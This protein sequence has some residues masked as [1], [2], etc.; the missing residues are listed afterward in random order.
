MPA[1]PLP[2]YY[3]ILGVEPAAPSDTIKRA[4]RRQSAVSHPDKGGSVGTFRL[5]QIAYETLADPDRRTIYDRARTAATPQEAQAQHQPPPPPPPS[6]PGRSTGDSEASRNS[7]ESPADAGEYPFA[8]PKAEPTAADS[9]PA[10]T[11]PRRE[12]AAAPVTPGYR[13]GL[14]PL[15]LC[16]ALDLALLFAAFA[17]WPAPPVPVLF[18]LVSAVGAPLCVWL[19]GRP[20]LVALRWPPVAAF[21]A[22]AGGFAVAAW[23]TRAEPTMPVLVAL[24]AGHLIVTLLAGI[25]W[26][27]WRRTRRLNAIVPRSQLAGALVFGTPGAGLSA[28]AAVPVREVAERLFTLAHNTSGM[29]VLHLAG[30][31]AGDQLTAADHVVLAGTKVAVVVTYPVPPARTY[32]FD[33]YGNL[34]ADGQHFPND[35]AA[36]RHA[37]ANLQSRLPR[38]FVTQGW[39]ITHG[40]PAV[41]AAGAADSLVHVAGADSVVSAVNG[42]LSDQEPVIHRGALA[43]LAQHA[44][45]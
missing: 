30:L 41:P 9:S 7:R 37:V 15:L 36:F 29:S 21:A 11:I 13:R 4:Y 32:S 10:P 16:A 25:S 34:L 17:N 2:D 3:E 27:I 6:T 31:P 42:W 35:A 8:K 38:R 12:L 40:R 26:R 14:L 19:G 45:S 1:S 5:V 24:G 18:L 33:G 20:D 44:A 28:A 43:V 23:R 22:L 39:I